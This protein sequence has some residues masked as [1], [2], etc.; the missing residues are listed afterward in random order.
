MKK[1]IPAIIFFLVISSAAA[2]CPCMEDSK[3]PSIENQ[4]DDSINKSLEIE[5][6]IK[7]RNFFMRMLYGS[8]WELAGQLKNETLANRERIQNC[9]NCPKE[10]EKE[11]ERLYTFAVISANMRGL[12]GWF[13]R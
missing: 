10:M 2:L 13:K 12:F 9:E 7:S 11:N 6:Q 5:Q 1:I 4:V 8:D 3:A